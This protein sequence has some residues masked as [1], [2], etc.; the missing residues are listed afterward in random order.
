MRKWSLPPGQLEQSFVRGA[1][2]RAE[3]HRKELAIGR[4]GQEL[5]VGLA[6]LMEPGA[7]LHRRGVGIHAFQTE[8][9]VCLAAAYLEPEGDDYR[10][11]Y[12]VLFARS[13]YVP[14]LL[15]VTRASERDRRRSFDGAG[16]SAAR[17]TSDRHEARRA[18]RP[19]HSGSLTNAM[20]PWPRAVTL[21]AISGGLVVKSG[22]P[23]VAR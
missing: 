6:D 5:A 18:R 7:H 1:R 23:S 15:N 11:R 19:S 20:R 2:L 4:R 12:A 8:G 17:A 3:I 14:A 22:G 9:G 21:A 10:Y 13:R 16:L